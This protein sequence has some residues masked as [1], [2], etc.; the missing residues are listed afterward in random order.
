MKR[1]VFL[2]AV[3]LAF[4]LVLPAPVAMAED[5]TYVG[6]AF[7]TWPNENNWRDSQNQINGYPD[8][9][10]D[11]A[12]VPTGKSVLVTVSDIPVGVI[13]V[14]TGVSGD[15]VIGIEGERMLSLGNRDGSSTVNGRIEFR[16]CYLCSSGTLAIVASTTLTGSGT[17]LAG[18]HYTGL[19]GGYI[20]TASGQTLTSE[21]VLEGQLTIPA[22][23]TNNGTVKVAH[24]SDTLELTENVTD[25]TKDGTGD[26]VCE[27]GTLNLTGQ[28]T[29]AG[30]GDWFLSD[31]DAAGN[32]RIVIGSSVSFDNTAG[33]FVIFG[34]ELD[35]YTDICTTGDLTFEDPDLTDVETWIIIRQ[36]NGA[37]FNASS[38]P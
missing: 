18:N 9:Y 16:D 15:G 10:D 19:V 1:F 31:D 27:A 13:D 14:Q 2:F 34:G 7:G 30:T 23:L 25:D 8:G 28:F 29:M 21:V 6:A 35:T 4:G 36:G 33:N 32:S 12:I 38:C 37:T 17:V 22:R 11:K 3:L 5:Y 26:W 24:A 20:N